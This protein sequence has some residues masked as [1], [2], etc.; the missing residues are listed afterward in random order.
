[1]VTRTA[2]RLVSAVGHRSIPRPL[3]GSS[4]SLSFSS[5]FHQPRQLQQQR[6]WNHGE[7]KS[8][9]KSGLGA[10]FGSQHEHKESMLLKGFVAI[11]GILESGVNAVKNSSI[12]SLVAPQQQ[13]VHKWGRDE[14]DTQ[15]TTSSTTG[16]KEK[17]SSPKTA[18]KKEDLRVVNVP[19]NTEVFSVIAV[20]EPV[21]HNAEEPAFEL[22][23]K[24]LMSKRFKT[25]Q[26][27][28]TE[29]LYK[30]MPDFSEVDFLEDVEHNLM[31]AFLK[32][33]WE[34]DRE[35]LQAMCSE[36][37]YHVNVET[38][39]KQYDNVKSNCRLLMTRRAS[40]FNRLMFIDDS[41]YAM[42]A[43]K[44][45]KQGADG[46]TLEEIDEDLDADIQ[47]EPEAVFFVSCSAH[48]ENEWVDEKGEVKQGGKDIPED[49][50]FVFGL[51]PTK[52]SRWILSTLE[53]Q[54]MQAMA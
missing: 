18:K 19:I 7:T 41:E 27:Q 35:A 26:Q 51:T 44:R 28:A 33:F 47:L 8:E 21:D 17:T 30:T 50:Y 16:S 12:W 54:K 39:L 4:P 42:T 29:V 36:A 49:W 1:M 25:T 2:R 38:Y 10:H 6:R 13:Q 46:A 31:P 48:V 45:S 37:C 14:D 32:A 15:P 52:G 9:T 24:L 20:G 22:F 11:G 34:K 53:F 40:L 3:L 43:H 5:S 23:K